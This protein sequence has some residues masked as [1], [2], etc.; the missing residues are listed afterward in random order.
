VTKRSHPEKT[1]VAREVADYYIKCVNE[2]RDGDI[3]S[4]GTGT[5]VDKNYRNTKQKAEVIEDIDEHGKDVKTVYHSS[6][7]GRWVVGSDVHT[8]NGDYIRTDRNNKRADNLDNI[9]EC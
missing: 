8:V 5:D 2:N 3:E 9:P 6:S 7:K 1:E 4:V